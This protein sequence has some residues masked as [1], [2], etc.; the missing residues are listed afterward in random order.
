MR[1]VTSA[2]TAAARV[3][4]VAIGH[5]IVDVLMPSDDEFL[6]R[7]RLVKGSMELVEADR[8]VRLYDDMILHA[9][10]LRGHLTEMSGGSAANTAVVVAELGGA[11]AFFGKVHDDPLGHTYRRDMQ[12]AGV[13]FE[14][15]MTV[16][17]GTPT[18][19]CLINV[20]PDAERTMCTFLGAARG[21]RVPDMD[22]SVLASAQVTYLEGYLWDEM[23]ARPALDHAM[24]T[25]HK[26]GQRFS[27]SLSDPFCVDRFRSEWIE[28]I[29]DH[30]DILF[31][32]EFELC[33][34]FETADFDGALRRVRGMCEIAAITRGAE[35]S[36][37]V[38]GHETT[39]VPAFPVAHVVDTTGAGDAYAG[40]FLFG[41][42]QGYDL[43][44]CGEL[45][46]IAAAEIISHLG[47]RPTPAL[48]ELIAHPSAQK[49]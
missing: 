49:G 33:S 3:D 13:R 1:P 21:L 31:G 34:L 4:V 44:R 40:G 29:A 45:G 27:L 23:N 25:V 39:E 20:S 8:A 41:F 38:N 2:H 24:T 17:N 47:G 35:G 26:A 18:G 22:V 12:A 37:I 5:A 32:N 16:G 48:H 11:A 6:A 15:T 30:V 36:I 9:G 19:R 14:S 28:L 46:G 43:G 7:H 42:T 10:A